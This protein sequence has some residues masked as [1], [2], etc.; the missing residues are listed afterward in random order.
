MI[1]Q[2]TQG[3]RVSVKT[4]FE[5][6]LFKNNKFFHLFAY[7]ITIENKGKDTVQ[8]IHRYLEFFDP[9]KGKE[10]IET[11][12]VNGEKPII[13]SGQSFSFSSKHLFVSPIGAI[14]GFFTMLNF[15]TTQKVMITIPVFRLASICALN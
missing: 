8:I 11:D 2:V 5:E 12:G 4:N 1:F 15:T 13:K 6:S 3:I 14:K 9:L 7:H 10:T